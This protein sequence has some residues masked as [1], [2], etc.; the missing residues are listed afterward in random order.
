[1]KGG[2]V[3]NAFVLVVFAKF[4]GHSAPLVAY[5]RKVQI[6]TRGQGDVY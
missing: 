3:M 1:M 2:P 6:T 4:G 5:C